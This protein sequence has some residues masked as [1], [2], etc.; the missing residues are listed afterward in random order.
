MFY[1][2]EGSSVKKASK[3]AN[4]NTANTTQVNANNADS[5]PPENATPCAQEFEYCTIPN[6]QTA[7]V[8][9]GAK[10]G[11]YIQ[12]TQTGK[13]RCHVDTFGGED[14]NIGLIESCIYQLSY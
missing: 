4:R 3:A 7:T 1:I 2:A 9:Y 8:W 13:F 10:G 14:P 6:G 5:T 12:S 11:K